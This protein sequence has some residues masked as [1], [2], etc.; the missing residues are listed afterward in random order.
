MVCKLNNMDTKHHCMLETHIRQ[1]Q[2]TI[3]NAVVKVY[4]VDEVTYK[5]VS[6]WIADGVISEKALSSH[7]RKTNAPLRTM[8]G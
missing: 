3:W 6:A 1:R 7:I 5:K 4:A 8:I 2:Q